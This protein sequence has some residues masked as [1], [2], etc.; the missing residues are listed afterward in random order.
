MSAKIR[1][2]RLLLHQFVGVRDPL[3]SFP[4]V[5]RSWSTLELNPGSFG[6]TMSSDIG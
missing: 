6:N 5:P 2:F 1:G 4:V 3:F